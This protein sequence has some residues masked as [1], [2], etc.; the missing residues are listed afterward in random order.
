MDRNKLIPIVG[1]VIALIVLWFLFA[2]TRPDSDG[3][4]DGAVGVDVEQTEGGGIVV[5]E[6]D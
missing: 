4:E 5:E 2:A 6:D 3:L 1:V